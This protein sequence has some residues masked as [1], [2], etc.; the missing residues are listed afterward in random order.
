MFQSYL[1]KLHVYQVKVLMGLE[2]KGFQY[3]AMIIL[4]PNKELVLK[5]GWELRLDGLS[6]L[7]SKARSDITSTA[8]TVLRLRVF[9]KHGKPYWG[10]ELNLI[11]W[12]QLKMCR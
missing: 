10:L 2:S 7:S 5:W 4:K 1:D 8:S 12:K 3:L 11:E 6:E 9:L